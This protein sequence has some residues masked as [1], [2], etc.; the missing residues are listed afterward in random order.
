MCG[1]YGALVEPS[2]PN[3]G[4]HSANLDSATDDCRHKCVEEV[5]TRRNEL[6]VPRAQVEPLCLDITR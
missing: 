5:V 4:F 1:V 3:V 6:V 2:G